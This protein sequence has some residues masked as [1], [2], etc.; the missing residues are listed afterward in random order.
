[1][2]E[3]DVRICYSR[4]QNDICS[5][6]EEAVDAAWVAERKLCCAL[7]VVEST[8]VTTAFPA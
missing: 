4:Q 7:P 6:R 5:H 1:M 8:T 2:D 3:F